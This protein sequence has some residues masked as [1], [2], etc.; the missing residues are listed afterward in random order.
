VS[1]PDLFNSPIKIRTKIKEFFK[2]PSEE[3]KRLCSIF[4]HLSGIKH[5][6]PVMSELVFGGRSTASSISF[7]TGAIEDGF[8]NTFSDLLTRFSIYQLAWCCHVVNIYVAKYTTVD[9]QLGERLQQIGLDHANTEVEIC[10][11]MQEVTAR[12]RGFF[13]LRARREARPR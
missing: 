13:G 7:S 3:S 8:T 2:D 10:S 11:F 5:A 12:Q 9:R 4:T 6:N 1:H